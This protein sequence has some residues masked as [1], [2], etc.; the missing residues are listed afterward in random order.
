MTAEPR[1]VPITLPSFVANDGEVVAA[2]QT[3]APIN[4]FPKDAVAEFD[5]NVL[6]WI[7]KRASSIEAEPWQAD[8]ESPTKGVYW[9]KQ[10]RSWL[11]IKKADESNA[12]RYKSFKVVDEEDVTSPGGDAVR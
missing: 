3:S 1:N 8:H 7:F 5:L 11:A 10:K 12:V 4:P 6:T 9:H 2:V